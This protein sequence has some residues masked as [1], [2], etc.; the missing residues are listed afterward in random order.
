MEIMKVLLYIILLPF[1]PFISG[2]VSLVNLTKRIPDEINNIFSD[3][4]YAI[5][6]RIEILLVIVIMFVLSIDQFITVGKSIID[7]SKVHQETSIE[8]LFQQNTK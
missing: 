1:L 5:A 8:T 3:F 6:G 4:K 2:V 7:N